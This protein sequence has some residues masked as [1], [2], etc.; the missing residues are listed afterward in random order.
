MP[1]HF[2]MSASGDVRDQHNNYV[3]AILASTSTKEVS[4]TLGLI[5]AVN[6]FDFLTY[7]LSARAIVEII[8]T[9]RYLVVNRVRPIVEEM[10]AA[11][12]Y[13]VTH[14]QRLIKEEDIYLRGTRFDWL[15]FFENGFRPLN[16]RYAEW[17][18]EKRKDKFAKKWRPGAT[19]PVEQVNVTTC[20]ERWAEAEP[21]V[22]V[23]YD[24]LCDMVHPNIGSAMS[25]TVPHEDGIRFKVRDRESEGVKLF[26]YSFSAFMSL[27][28]RE[29]ARLFQALF[30]LFLL[31]DDANDT[32]K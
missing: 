26:Q 8:A 30:S 11:G 4:L 12:K 13:D 19:P 18:A 25:V 14:V 24:L 17:L 3:R 16:E 2:A 9:L 32:F 7:A 31:T 27:T 6:K 23:L 29:E 1:K 5:E 15:E 28:G 20:L 22:G 10:R 21:G